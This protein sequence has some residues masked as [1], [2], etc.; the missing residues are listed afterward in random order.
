MTGHA[1]G[2]TLERM[3]LVHATSVDLE[4]HGVLLRGAPSSGKSDLALRLIDGGARLVSDDQTRLRREGRRLI[5]SAPEA[6]AGR[7]EVR[8]LGIVRVPAATDVPLVL[9]VDLASAEQVERSPEPAVCRF[10]DVEVPCLAL[11][12]FEA[13][14]V[15]KLRLAV[16]NRAGDKHSRDE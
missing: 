16:Q 4:G 5:M 6:I 1:R 9:V 12:P 11:A 10:L 2:L 13:S 15:A 14:A 8:G 3:H 7:L